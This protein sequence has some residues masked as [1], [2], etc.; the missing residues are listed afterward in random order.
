MSRLAGLESLSSALA[1]LEGKR[2]TPEEMLI[3]AKAAY[4]FGNQINWDVSNLNI[5]SGEE[6]PTILSLINKLKRTLEFG[7]AKLA[8]LISYMDPTRDPVTVMGMCQVASGVHLL[9]ELGA[10]KVLRTRKSFDNA[11]FYFLDSCPKLERSVTLCAGLSTHWWWH[12]ISEERA[13]VH[14][15]VRPPH[16]STAASTDQSQ[17]RRRRS[18]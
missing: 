1:R 10:P 11:I 9:G 17:A 5:F 14:R 13:T 4:H 8:H 6:I 2:S 16:S 15:V 7:V 3:V 18:F 12:I